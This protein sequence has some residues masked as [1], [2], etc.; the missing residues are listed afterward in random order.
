MYIRVC[1]CMCVLAN[2]WNK[3]GLAFVFVFSINALVSFCFCW[4]VL[5]VCF[6]CL[7]AS[8]LVCLFKRMVACLFYP[9]LACLLACSQVAAFAPR[10]DEPNAWILARVVREKPN[11][12]VR[13]NSLRLLLVVVSTVVLVVLV[14]MVLFVLL[15]LVVY[16]QGLIGLNRTMYST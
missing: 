8:L 6:V 3:G 4:F 16:N 11:G 15:L 10:P 14:V 1:V 5:L 12:R 13:D 2:T 7:F 9:S